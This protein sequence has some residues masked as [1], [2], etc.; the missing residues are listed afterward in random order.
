ME[1]LATDTRGLD[2]FLILT[3]GRAED[4]DTDA[5]SWLD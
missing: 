4:V 1:V 2:R 3:T 5:V